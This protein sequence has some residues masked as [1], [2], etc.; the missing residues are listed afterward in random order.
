MRFFGEIRTKK[1]AAVQKQLILRCH[2]EPKPRVELRG[3]EESPLPPVIPNAVR[4]LRFFAPL[5][6]TFSDRSEHCLTLNTA[7]SP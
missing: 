4:N 3:S 6:M 2:S 1:P 7:L 5:R